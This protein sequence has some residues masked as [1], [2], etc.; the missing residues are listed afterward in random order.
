[1]T[2]LCVSRST[3]ERERVNEERVLVIV[4]TSIIGFI[5]IIVI[6]VV[7][8]AVNLM[9]SCRLWSFAVPVVVLVANYTLVSC[10]QCPTPLQLTF[11]FFRNFTVYVTLLGGRK[12]SCRGLASQNGDTA[13]LR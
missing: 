13:V 3:V 7:I 1:M 11:F 9:G 8:V 6:V 2:V 12:Q 5:I 4:L 10:A